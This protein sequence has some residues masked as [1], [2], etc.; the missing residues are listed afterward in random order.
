MRPLISAAA[1]RVALYARFSSDQQRDASIDDQIRVCRAR[2]DRD[3]WSVAEV[4]TDYAV[5]GATAQRPGFQ[6]LMAA[7]RAGRIDVV[8]A[9]SLDRLSRDQE[10]IAGFFKQASFAGA[11]IVTLAEGEV[12]E[13]HVGLKGTMGALYLKDLADKTR[14]GLEGRVR[15]GRSGG[16]LS[17]GY[18][19]VRGPI[20]RDGEFERGLREIDPVQAA[21][22]RRIFDAFAA[23]DSPIAIAKALNAEG[24][25][26]PRGGPWSD[27][28]LRGHAR[29]GTGI[30]RNALYIGRLVWNR[31][32][33]LK[34]PH[35]GGRVARHNDEAA[36]VEEEVPELR[37]IPQPVWDQVQHRLSAVARPQG[38]RDAAPGSQALWQHR[39]AVAL[40]SGK[41]VC[42]ACGGAYATNGK[43]YMGCKAAERQGT[44]QNRTRIRRSR[45]EAQVLEALATRLMEPDA[46]AVFVGEFT[47]EWNRLSAARSG[48]AGLRRRELDQVERQLNGLIDAIADGLRAPGLQ[49]KLDGLAARQEALR[50]ELASIEMQSQAPRLHPNL[51]EIYRQRVSC[52]REGLDTGGGREVLEAARALIARV[53]VHPA[54]GDGQQPRLELVGEI[55]ALL[56]AAGV[57][58]V[59]GN[60]KSPLGLSSGLDVLCGSVLGDAGT[61]FE[62]VTFRL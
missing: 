53:E 43:D 22:V 16:G 34:D 50:R 59:G 57:E 41:V 32:R 29:V 7:L 11:R 45:V 60:T 19:V 55:S 25:P 39:R 49:Q 28:A 21:V 38:L 36:L 40:L 37:I 17:Y 13:L 58:G 62:P 46:V 42:G 35:T 47:A 26:G 61:G 3:G 31:R 10:H 5:S 8:L 52:L 44:C 56:S 6:G 23:G 30:L 4:F 51:S 54:S 1:P 27:G 14:R 15:Q 24:V 2:A 12:S 18:R 20:G 48:E 9:E 33:W